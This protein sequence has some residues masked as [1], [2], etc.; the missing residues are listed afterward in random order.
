MFLNVDKL[1]KENFQENGPMATFRV[2]KTQFQHF[3]DSRF[4]LDDDD[5]RMTSKYFL[6]YARIE[7]QQFHNTLIQHMESVKKSIDEKAL[8]KRE[9]DSMVNERQLQTEEGNVNTGKPLDASLVDT[10]SRKQPIYDE[11]PMAEVQTTTKLNVFATERQHVEQP[12]LNNE[13]EVDQN[14]E[15]CHDKHPLAASLTDSKTTKLSNQSLKKHG[16]FLKAKSNEAKVK[17]D[18]DDFKTINIELEYSVAT[19]LKENEHLKKTY[20]DLF[21]SIKRT[22]AQTKDHH[23][24]LIAQLDKK[25]IENADLKAQI[26]KKVF[27]NAALKSELRKL[28]R[29]SFSKSRFASQVDEKDV[30]SKPVTPQSRPNVREYA[31][32]KPHQMIADGSSRYSLNDMIHNYYLEEARKKTQ[33]LMTPTIYTNKL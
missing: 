4:S 6:E 24:S 7:V 15:Q 12:E 8:H 33:E 9:Y 25:F 29:N 27:A 31:F 26:Q 2:L 28:T 10:E 32:A 5:G 30:L 21:D 3:I 1:D 14:A 23:D 18:I 11:E 17:K 16:Q 20:Q 19:L 13:G 22:R